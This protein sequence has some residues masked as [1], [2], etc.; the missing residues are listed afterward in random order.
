MTSFTH[1]TTTGPTGAS[2]TNSP[3][4]D[5]CDCGCELPPF[6]RNA[7]WYGKLLVPQD[8]IDE[9]SYFREKIRHHNQRLHG[10]GVVCGLQVH[11]DDAAACRDRFVVLEPGSAID[12]CGNE[13]LV[14][15]T[16]RVELAELIRL[17]AG[18]DAPHEVR[19]CLC[20]RECPTEPVPVLYDE[21]GCDDDR[22]LPN[23]I[24]ESFEVCATLDPPPT[25]TTWTGP[26]LV[27]DTDLAIA[28]ATHVRTGAGAV[29]VAAGNSVYR[30]DPAT[31]ATTGSHDLGGPVHALELSGDAAHVFA[32][33]DDASAV[34]TLTVLATADLSVTGSAAVPGGAAAPVSTA[35]GSDGR[36]CLLSPAPGVLLRYEPDLDTATPTAPATIAVPDGRGLLAVAANAETAYLAAVSGSGAANPTRI[37]VVDLAAG[38]LGTAIDVL[39]AGGEPTLLDADDAGALVVAASDGSCYA[40]TLPAGTLAGSVP[41]PGPVSAAAGAPWA[42]PISSDGTHSQ[43]RALRLAGVGSGSSTAVGPA[44]GWEGV[45]RDVAIGTGRV[46]VAYGG[47]PGGVAVFDV[48]GGSCRDGWDA[49]PVCPSCAGHECVPLA[50]LHGYRAGFTVLDPAEPPSDPATDLQQGIARIDDTDGRSVLRSTTLLSRTI[51][52]LLECCEQVHDGGGGGGGQGPAGPQGPTGPQGPSGPAGPAGPAG[53]TGP[54]GPAGATGPEGPAGPAGPGLEPD[55]TRIAALSWK[56]AAAMS[57]ADLQTVIF[58][59]GTPDERAAFGVTVEFTDEVEVGPIDAVHVFTV[60]APNVALPQAQKL[61]FACRCPIA[62][63]VAAVDATVDAGGLIVKAVVTGAATSKAISFVFDPQFVDAV[64]RERQLDDLFVHLR[65][66]FVLDRHGRAVDAEFT[67]AGLPTGDRPAGSDFGIQGGMFDSWFQPVRDN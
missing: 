12:C 21:C 50:T 53:A 18:D 17:P 7:Y 39:P 52:C 19:L 30:V 37:D 34:L 51:E 25:D 62:G 66:E 6:V 57:I 67:R 29:L 41:L 32:A 23:R 11:Q 14:T 49:P 48:S 33:H 45:A 47:D 3:G 16:T 64:L 22:C 5:C 46:Y 20:Y 61:G 28:D 27:R 26:A 43:V 35:V 9:Q 63:T 56:H 38:A 65:G 15:E 8:F 13:I 60:D 2:G 40:I 59:A 10:T 4:H 44:I 31:G 36:L 42:Y 24:L 1:P 58:N 54:A 55:L